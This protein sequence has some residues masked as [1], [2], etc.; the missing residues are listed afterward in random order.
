M[1][2]NLFAG[3]FWKCMNITSGYVFNAT[4]VTMNLTMTNGTIVY[5]EYPKINELAKLCMLKFILLENKVSFLN[6]LKS[7]QV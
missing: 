1:G 7:A 3:K 4:N 5:R 6:F 2:V